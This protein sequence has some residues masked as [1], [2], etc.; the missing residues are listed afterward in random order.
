M[1]I[2]LQKIRGFDGTNINS[3]WQ[4]QFICF[5]NPRN[6]FVRY[7]IPTEIFIYPHRANTAVNMDRHTKHFED[8]KP[9]FIN[10]NLQVQF[11]CYDTT[12]P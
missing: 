11:I 4:A 7:E 9:Q 2:N 1:W 3:E 6:C 12:P 8:L 5:K 10:E